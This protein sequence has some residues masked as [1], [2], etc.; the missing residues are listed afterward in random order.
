MTK[1]HLEKTQSGVTLS[2]SLPARFDVMAQ[3]DLPMAEGVRMAHQIRQDVWRALR[4]VRGFSPVVEITRKEGGLHIKAGGRAPKP[5][6][7]NT[8]ERIVSV[9][10]NP[11]NRAR[12]LRCAGGQK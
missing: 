2:R 12:W 5:I 7:R 6:A 11:Q 8:V 4:N 9:L 3:T 1:W 10:E